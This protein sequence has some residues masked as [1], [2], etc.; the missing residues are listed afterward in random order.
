MHGGGE[1]ER[2]I[3]FISLVLFCGG[4]SAFT[5]IVSSKE[6]SDGSKISRRGSMGR[7]PRREA[8]DSRG[9]YASKI[10]YVKTKGSGPLGG[11]GAGGAALD[12]P[13]EVL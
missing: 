11:G 13:Q 6:V 8:D 4:N 2:A 10:L 1:A 3:L 12:P 7:R 9:G 5:G